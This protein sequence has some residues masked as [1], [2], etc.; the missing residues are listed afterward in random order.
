MKNNKMKKFTG[1]IYDIVNRRIIHGSIFIENGYIVSIEEHEIDSDANIILPGFIDSHVHV[2]SSMLIPS[3]FSKL[4]IPNGTVAIVSDPHEI[5]NVL[6]KDGVKFMIENAK[7]TPLKTFFCAPSCVPATNFE[8][9]GANLYAED[10]DDILNKLE[11]K[12]LG[13]MMNYPG[14][15]FEDENVIEK[16]NVAKKYKAIIDGHIPGVSGENLEKYVKS[17]ISTDHECFTYEEALEKIKL[18][19]KILIREGSAAK[20][21]EELFPLIS[22]FNT[23]CMLCTDDSHPDDII[24]YGHI[25]NIIKKV[26]KQGIN[27]FDLLRVASLNPI[28]HY[29][30]PVGLLQVKDPADFVIINNLEDF[31]IK[32]TII[33]GETVYSDGRILFE[34]IKENPVNN[35]R[36]KKISINDLYVKD[37]NRNIKVIEIIDKELITR[38]FSYKLNSENTNLISDVKKDILKIVVY[39]RYKETSKPTIGFIHGIGIK[40][41]AVAS[42][43]AHDSHNII[44]VGTSDEDIVNAINDIVDNKGGLSF[45]EGKNH[46]TIPLEFA[47]LM[48]QENPSKLA[49]MYEVLN[50][51]IKAAGS[52]LTAPFMTLS[53]MALLV[54]PELKIGD[55]GLFDVSTFQFTS[56][57]EE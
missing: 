7:Q 46:Y 13:E 52:T 16:L 55:K 8:T 9:S 57:Y 51:R 2:E 42:S 29:N 17:G 45:V 4:V 24:K 28:K 18:G 23:M 11:V 39:N 37:E 12:I 25:N 35:F 21:L 33:N 54:I 38:S 44:A 34:T 20:N 36:A 40:Y 14:V 43:I 30:L 56:L 26:L 50:S 49:E 1:K 19:M 53:F 15:I 41:G 47:G 6:G 48:T 3:E 10:I 5:A 32:E 31:H 27:I 22:N